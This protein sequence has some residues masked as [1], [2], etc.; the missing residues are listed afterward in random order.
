MYENC[1]AL[2]SERGT[3]SAG[4][5]SCQSISRGKFYEILGKITAGGEKIQLCAVDYVSG[6]FVNDQITLLQRIVDD[7]VDAEKRPMLTNYITIMCIFL[8]QHYDSHV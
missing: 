3:N 6:G 4:G 5:D 8:I 2:C 7:I 1:M